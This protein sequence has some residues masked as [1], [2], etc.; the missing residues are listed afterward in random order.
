MK[1]DQPKLHVEKNGG[2]SRP[3]DWSTHIT[4]SI[5][6]LLKDVFNLVWLYFIMPASGSRDFIDVQR[7]S[8]D[9]HSVSGF[10][11]SSSKHFRPMSQ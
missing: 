3:P 7:I 8:P 11:Q 5:K 10:L 6:S 4:V 9:V 1:K 2:R